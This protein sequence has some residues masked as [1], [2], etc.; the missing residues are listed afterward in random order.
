MP[1]QCPCAQLDWSNVDQTAEHHPDCREMKFGWRGGVDMARDIGQMSEVVFFDDSKI[2]KELKNYDFNRRPGEIIAFISTAPQIP[3]TIDELIAAMELPFGV[4]EPTNGSLSVTGEPYVALCCGGIKR[5]GERIGVY[6]TYEA[7]AVE[8]FYRE[9]EAYWR[10]L[11]HGS[12]AD[13]KLYWRQKPELRARVVYD[14]TRMYQAEPLYD[15]TTLYTV[16]ARLL[17]SDK[18]PLQQ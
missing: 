5:E 3:R 4:G 11:F 2:R 13:W 15:A 8:F 18:P 17:V 6:C 7:K 16:T 10:D 12:W 9:W 14:K 1:E